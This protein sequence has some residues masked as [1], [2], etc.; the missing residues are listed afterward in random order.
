MFTTVMDFQRYR[1]S[2]L[3]SYFL[4]YFNLYF[5]FNL[6]MDL[7]THTHAHIR[8]YRNI[9]RFFIAIIYNLK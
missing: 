6:L 5:N 8:T 7:H 3:E 4:I 2:V 9:F 1:R